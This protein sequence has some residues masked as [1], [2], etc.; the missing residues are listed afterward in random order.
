MWGTRDPR[1]GELRNT[2]QRKAKGQAVGKS[3][4]RGNEVKEKKGRTT[5]IQ[6]LNIPRAEKGI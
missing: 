2:R 5:K 4:P 1:L 3:K 6:T